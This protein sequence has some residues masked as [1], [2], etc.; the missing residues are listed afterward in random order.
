MNKKLKVLASILTTVVIAGTFAGCGKQTGNTA[1]SADK[2]HESKEI[3]VWSHLQENE[4]AEVK[5][6]AEEWAKKTGNTVKVQRDQS[7]F[8]A[9]LQAAN[10]SKAP[11]IMFGIAHD[12]LGTFH[13][14][15]LLAEMPDGT[16]DKSK[17]VE[18]TL[19]AVSYDGKMYGIPISMETYALFYNTE[20]VKSAPETLDDL[21]AQAQKV[22]FQYDINNFYFSYAFV[23]GN[24]GY[25]FKNNGGTLD[26]KDIGLGNEGAVKAYQLLAD[27]TQKYK[28]MPAT[29]RSDDAKANFQKGKIG[30]YISGP[31]DVD[32]FKKAGTKFAVAPL[33]SVNGKACPS[34]MGVQAAFV[35]SKSKN[36]TEAWDLMKYLVEN[37]SEP[38]FKAGSRIPVLKAELEKDDIKNNAM[39]TAFAKQAENAEP[40]PNI[41]EMAAV[42]TPAGDNL[43][44]ITQGKLKP[45]DA[46]KQITQQ[47][48]QGI[49][50]QK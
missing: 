41:S 28:F 49:A 9:Y 24:G 5:K 15:G 45:A 35:N 48:T 11:D 19:N 26:P 43:T 46:G 18:S 7:T 50:Q 3:T 38:L 39:F 14:A 2:K 30:L 17:Y 33:P 34:F 42:W 10:S 40:M 20:K 16:I 37:T 44:L 23:A 29:I 13:K 21:I 25:V 27:F 31:W 32:G 4:V 8:Q 12:N 1:A 47:I 6:A 36:Q 22:G